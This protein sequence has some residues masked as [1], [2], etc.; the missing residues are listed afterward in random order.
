M[1]SVVDWFESLIS[2]YG[3]RATIIIILTIIVVN[4]IKIPIVKAAKTHAGKHNTDKAVITRF[5]TFLPF[6]VSFFFNFIWELIINNFSFVSINYVEIITSSF[7]YAGLAIASF[8]S[9]KKQVQAYT[10]KTI[11][12][13]EVKTLKEVENH[14]DYYEK[15]GTDITE[16]D[17]TKK[18]L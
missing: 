12:K 15:P 17:I 11:Q 13:E 4:I 16:N 1:E 6:L 10:A 7:I 9:I 3:F 14:K 8:E 5:V 18:L 2:S